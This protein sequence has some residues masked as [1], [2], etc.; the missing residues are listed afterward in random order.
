MLPLADPQRFIGRHRQLVALN[1]ALETRSRLVTLHG[2]S[3][4]GKSRL[5]AEHLLCVANDR[6]TKAV[7]LEDAH[8]LR[9]ALALIASAL[10]A[11]AAA[12]PDPVDVLAERLRELGPLTLVLDHVDEVSAELAGPLSRWLE[13]CPET[14]FVSTCHRPLSVA[15]EHPCVVEPLSLPISK[16]DRVPSDALRLWH[17]LR[18]SEAKRD[19]PV[20][21][22]L[23]DLLRAL[24]GLPLLIEL[25]AALAERLT[26]FALLERLSPRLRGLGH[27]PSPEL[28]L[29]GVLETVW[30]SMAEA[31]R[32]AFACCAVFGTSFDRDAYGVVLA[33]AAGAHSQ[34]SADDAIAML[35]QRRLLSRL[36]TTDGTERYGLHPAV[37]VAARAQLTRLDPGG[38][39]ERAHA[40]YFVKK[41]AELADALEGRDGPEATRAL[42]REQSNLMAIVARAPGAD[43]SDFALHLKALCVHDHV[44]ST[45]GPVDTDL[46]RLDA[47]LRTADGAA[48][49]STLHTEALCVRAF[50][51][52]RTGALDGSFADLEMRGT[53]PAGRV[54]VTVAFVSLSAGRLDEAEAEA[55]RALAIAEQVNHVRLKGI[56]LGVFALVRRV[57][58][59]EAE[60]RSLYEQALEHHRSVHNRRFEGIV[61]TRLAQLQLDAGEADAALALADEA[62]IVHRTFADRLMEGLC[63]EVQAT[64]AHSRGQLEDARA[65]LESARPLLAAG[66]A[67]HTTSILALLGRVRTELGDFDVAQRALNEAQRDYEARGAT[68]ESAL[69][70]ARAAALEA[71]S[72]DPRKAEDM[73][74]AVDSA[75]DDAWLTALV[76]L[77]RAQLDFADLRAAL[78]A[79]DAAAA[80]EARAR[81]LSRREALR[82]QL[83]LGGASFR[84]RADAEASLRVFDILLKAHADVATQPALK[85][86]LAARS[87]I[88]PG[89]E[90]V[91]MRQRPALRRILTRLAMHA[92]SAPGEPYRA[93]ELFAAGWPGENPGE[94][95]ARLQVYAVLGTLRKLGL[96]DALISDDRGHLLSA[97]T[98]VHFVS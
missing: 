23:V 13:S 31:E 12:G 97:R 67:G 86:S 87:M 61:M 25:I 63:L 20:D 37:R 68:V 4:V 17:M 42:V 69:C 51:L 70:R 38:K 27:S 29:R 30:S 39:V 24:S 22:E 57:R 71:L 84:M 36:H 83:A 53:Y 44:L 58:G 6:R 45:F 76:D 54:A 14:H 7:H 98:S 49:E 65:A 75:L 41:G 56:A 46:E 89:G 92:L 59:H 19:R 79:H 82:A 72:G 50:V 11:P 28:V 85:L 10:E 52:A 91:D 93:L 74:A 26:P 15:G 64:V 60:A 43:V 3:G 40:G 90:L 94:E 55:Q 96:G 73:F 48:I 18:G 88:T 9:D 78:S 66:G 33:Q 62:R 16:S 35:V 47:A 95:N 2:P 80:G 8:T 77:E 5:A 34:L 21:A 81:A 1:E 32:R